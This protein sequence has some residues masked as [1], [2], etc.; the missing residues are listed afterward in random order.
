VTRNAEPDQQNGIQE[1]R[2]RNT[3]ANSLF[4]RPEV[5]SF[6]AATAVEES[7]SVKLRTVSGGR[8]DA[9]D[10]SIERPQIKA[11]EEFYKEVCNRAINRRMGRVGTQCTLS[12]D[13]GF[14]ANQHKD[15]LL[16]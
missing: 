1:Y 6:R 16:Q 13:S 5:P 14:P 4:A 12:P 9:L 7:D 15:S 3:L 2:R 11:A 10:C 8:P